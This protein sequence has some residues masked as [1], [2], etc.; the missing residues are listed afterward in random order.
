MNQQDKDIFTIVQQSPPSETYRSASPFTDEYY[1]NCQKNEADNY[2]SAA[3]YEDA[4][5]IILF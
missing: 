3:D 2:R 1:K 4:T 5:E